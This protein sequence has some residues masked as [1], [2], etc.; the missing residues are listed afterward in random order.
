MALVLVLLAYQN[1]YNFNVRFFFHPEPSL[2]I[3]YNFI[4]FVIHVQ[5]TNYFEA[6]RIFYSD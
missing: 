2:S 4:R 1:V 5:C 3:N 6:Q